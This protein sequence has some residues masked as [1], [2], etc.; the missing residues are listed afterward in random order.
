MVGEDDPGRSVTE[1]KEQSMGLTMKDVFRYHVSAIEIATRIDEQLVEAEAHKVLEA[2]RHIDVDDGENNILAFLLSEDTLQTFESFIAL[3]EPQI[4]AA[5]QAGVEVRPVDKA[6]FDHVVKRAEQIRIQC[7]KGRQNPNF[8]PVIDA[9]VEVREMLKVIL[10][11]ERLTRLLV[12]RAHISDDVVSALRPVSRAYLSQ[13]FRE[14]SEKIGNDGRSSGEGL[15]AH[16]ARHSAL[17]S[18]GSEGGEAE[19]GS[20]TAPLC[21]EVATLMK[22]AE[23]LKR[24]V[25]HINLTGDPVIRNIFYFLEALKGGNFVKAG[26]C[27]NRFFGQFK[28]GTAEAYDDMA[29]VEE[30]LLE[31]IEAY[32]AKPK[33]EQFPGLRWWLSLDSPEYSAWVFEAM[34]LGLEVRGSRSVRTTV[35]VQDFKDMGIGNRDALVFLKPYVM[36]GA[37]IYR[38]LAE[39]YRI[40]ARGGDSSDLCKYVNRGKYRQVADILMKGLEVKEKP[41]GERVGGSETEASDADTPQFKV[42]EIFDV[43]DEVGSSAGEKIEEGV[44]D[45]SAVENSASGADRGPTEEDIER[46]MESARSRGIV[47]SGRGVR[48]NKAIEGLCDR[49]IATFGRFEDAGWTEEQKALYFE[50][51]GLTD[52]DMVVGYD[53]SHE[54]IEE[55]EEK[56]NALAAVSKEVAS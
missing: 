31:K 18:G 48:W 32:L 19:A 11:Q 49:F 38:K 36:D 40:M 16:T 6:M 10:N 4:Q 5:K 25:L 44:S 23:V 37:V 8:K 24:D 2:V 26:E 12:E 53:M 30:D 52:R 7:E 1:D 28:V 45:G 35:K 14:K 39:T 21:P 3:V 55:W 33:P 42:T 46:A 41:V 29:K 22:M 51:S 43:P 20:E 15:A 56:I 17:A 47:E 13:Y 50:I 9:R 34:L 27:L 54:K